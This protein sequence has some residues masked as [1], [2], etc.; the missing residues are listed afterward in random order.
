MAIASP[1]QLEARRLKLTFNSLRT[2]IVALVVAFCV[3]IGLIFVLAANFAYMSYYDELRQRQGLAFAQNVAQMY[4]ELGKFDSLNRED[5]ENRF[6]Q[7]LLLDPS[8]AIYLLDNEGRVRAGYTKERSIGSKSVLSLAPIKRLTEAPVGQTVYGEDPDFPNLLCLFAAAPLRN[9]ATTTGY[10][11]V[12]MRSPKV[13]TNRILMSSS[14]NRT[15]LYVALGATLVSALLVL[16]VLSLITRPLRRLTN[17]ADAVSAGDVESAMD[18]KA[19]P[20]ELR[21]DEIGRLSRA[22]RAMVMRLR[23]QVQRVRRMDATRRDWVASISH[24]LRTPLTSLMGHLETVQLRGEQMTDAER[25]RFLEVAMQNAKHLDRL[26]ASLFDFARLDSDELP[27]EK[28]PAH[29]GELLD[30]LAARFS[31]AGHF[32]NIKIN[33]DYAEGLPMVQIDVA[34]IERAV[35]NLI[36]NAM[37]YTPEGSAVTLS[38]KADADG[39]ALTVADSGPGIAPQDLPHVFERFFQ[40]SRHREGRGHAGLGLAIVQRVA[41]LHG[42]TV[43]A[44]NQASGGAAFTL[45]L[46][47]NALANV[48]PLSALPTS[49]LLRRGDFHPA[50]PAK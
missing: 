16:A 22:F 12:L 43:Q 37:R 38:A 25:K 8:S 11:Y 50:S 49:P 2:R 7:M 44:A 47:V 14:A 41:Q 15:A 48:T 40:G 4:P 30:D 13:D 24:D 9:G 32:R 28:A 3:L 31:A 23:E 6:E 34:L 20:Y 26:S 39:V 10:V 17:A 21:N 27:V 45:W 33:V 1:T 36:D 5:V 42:G 19:M 29:V 18:A 46:P 35:A